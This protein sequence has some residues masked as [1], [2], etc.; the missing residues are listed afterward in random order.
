MFS[1][2]TKNQIL[3]DSGLTKNQII[4]FNRKTSHESYYQAS[5]LT[6]EF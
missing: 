2:L 3:V 5:I 4:H 1:G 6:I